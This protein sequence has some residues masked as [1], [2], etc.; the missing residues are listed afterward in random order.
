MVRKLYLITIL[1]SMKATGQWTYIEIIGSSMIYNTFSKIVINSK[2]KIIPDL[3]DSCIKKGKLDKT[4]YYKNYTSFSNVIY[5]VMICL[6]LF[7]LE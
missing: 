1:N 2:N 4:T 6:L 7:V 5:K 3:S